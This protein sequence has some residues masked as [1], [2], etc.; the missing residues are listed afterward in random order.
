[1]S[2]TIMI[3]D[4]SNV[5]VKTGKLFLEN[6]GYKVISVSDGFTALTAIQDTM[7]ALVLLDIE[8]PRL[9]GYETCN[10]IKTNENY[11][12]IP[13]IMLSGKDGP[14]DKAKGKMSGCDDYLTKPFK[15]DELLLTISKY[16]KDSD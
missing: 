12:N 2:K 1:M 13:I 4:D 8:M 6:A 15:K 7:P 10:I 11:K 14:F 5:I 3:V 9:N 16:L